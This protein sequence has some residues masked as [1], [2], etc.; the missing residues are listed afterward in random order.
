MGVGKSAVGKSLSE[1]LGFSFVDTDLLIEDAEERKIS[2]IFK[3]D[4]EE[5][6]RGLETEVLETLS[7][8]EDLVIATGGGIVLR[9]K[10]VGILRDMGHIILLTA[11]P[12][13]ILKRIESDGSR[14]LLENGDKLQKI[15]DIL[16]KRKVVYESS[17]DFKVDTSDK[18]IEEVVEEI[19]NYVQ[20]KS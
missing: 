10:N 2:D 14:P 5:F 11:S 4:G 15:K 16:E 6:F 20:D 7:N 17:A 19:I 9:S 13:V 18:N 3:M 8:Y 12:D 1:K